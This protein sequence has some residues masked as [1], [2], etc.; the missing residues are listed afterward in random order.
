[1][2]Y[3]RGYLEQVKLLLQVLPIINEQDCFALKGGTAINLFL[4]DMPRLSVDIDLTYLPIEP[5]E[6]FL[7]N[8]TDALDVL[9]EN[10]RKRTQGQCKVDEVFLKEPRQISKLLIFNK[11]TR[12][13]IE[14]NLVLR[15]SVF[16]CE[17]HGLCQSAQDQFLTFFRIKT[18]SFAD[19]YAGKICAALARQHPR[20]LFDVKILLEN[21][22]LLE[23]IRQALVIYIASNSRPIHEI[24]NPTPNLQNMRKIYDEGFSG[25]TKNAVSYEELVQ[26]RYSLINKILK[27]LTS[28]EREFL[29]SVKEGE[30][31]WSLI[32]IPG[33]EKLPGLAWKNINIKKMEIEKQKEALEK[34]KKVL[35]L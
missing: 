27:E 6:I 2:S 11:E 3:S 23:P 34:L 10:I 14:P 16:E 35:D 8:I 31:K 22:G 12:I 13:I 9:A 20:D 21:D 24:L 28:N 33:I 32:P 15:G 18:L 17:T 1:V 25:M 19:I 7:R 29:L 30:P 5:R 26:V 4:R